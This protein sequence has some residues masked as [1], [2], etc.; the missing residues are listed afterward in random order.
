MHWLLTFEIFP[1]LAS[2]N[3]AAMNILVLGL[4]VWNC[5]FCK[6]TAV[7][8]QQFYTYS[9]T[10]YMS[11]SARMFAFCW[12][13]TNRWD[14]CGHLVGVGSASGDTAKW[15]PQEILPSYQSMLPSARMR[16]PRPCRSTDH[17]VSSF[18]PSLF[19]QVCN[20]ITV[21][22]LICVSLVTH[23]G[24]HVFIWSIGH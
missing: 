10:Y 18:C 1:I 21:W 2:M 11:F 6:S 15:S 14:C 7:R 20:G 22:V 8:C 12:I 19:P 5:S 9:S 16:V 13:D 4:T 17:S 3:N 24:E 23:K